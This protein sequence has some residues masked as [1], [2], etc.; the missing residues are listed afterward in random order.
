VVIDDSG[1]GWLAF[2]GGVASGGT[3]IYP[4]TTRICRL[5][6]DMMSVD[7]E[8]ATIPAPYFFEASELNYMG[9]QWVYTYNTS[10]KER[11]EWNVAGVDAP[12]SCSM[13]Y[14]TSTTPLQPDSWTF[15]GMTLRNPGYEGMEFGNNHTHLHKFKDTYYMLY[16][17]EHYRKLLGVASGYRSICIDA[18]DVNE[19]N[20]AISRGSMSHAGVNQLEPIDG[21]SVQPASQAS[22]T[23]GVSY[24]KGDADGQ[25]LM[26]ADGAGQAFR[27][28]MVDCAGVTRLRVCVKGEGKLY[29]RS[30]QPD[31]KL[32]AIA[33]FS[34]DDWT[35]Q[36]VKLNTK[37]KSLTD[38]CFS[39][40]GGDFLFR[41]WVLEK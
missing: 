6:A 22:A 8:V 31:G 26:H 24:V 40:A 4:G 11:T 29:L 20:A 25:M 18:I 32:L 33:S 36:E 34:A 41:E 23:R 35:W 21:F 12:G 15:K 19:Q 2:G 27:V 14:M 13:C 17:T 9:G 5:S 37:L 1:T 28:S 39:C 7:G 38:L 16:H 3:A 10:W 30:S